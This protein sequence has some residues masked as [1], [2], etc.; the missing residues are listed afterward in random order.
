MDALLSYVKFAQYY[1]WVMKN[2]AKQNKTKQNKKKEAKYEL[3]HDK[4]N[5]VTERPA[6]T[7]SSESS[8]SA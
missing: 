6:K 7:Q 4:T 1:T 8:L 3:R 2:I 5:K